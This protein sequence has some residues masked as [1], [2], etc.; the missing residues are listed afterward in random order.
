MYKYKLSIIIPTYNGAGW[1]EDTMESVLCQLDEYKDEVEFI[2]R[3]N[4]SSDNTD[5]IVEKLNNKYHGLIKYDRRDTT[6]LADI[7]YRESVNMSNGVFVLMIGDDDLLFPNFI[8]Y[9]LKL[10]DE[11][12][13]VSLFY[14]NRISTSRD[15]K[16][17]MLK[18]LNPNP[19]FF[20]KYDSPEEFIKDYSLGPDFM[21]VNVF[22][23]ECFDKGLPF[24]K[25]KYYG[26]EWYSIILAGLRGEKCMSLF[27]P[28]I[29]QRVPRQR[30][31]DDQALLF[32]VIG[33]HNMFSDITE[34]Y[35]SALQ[36]WQKNSKDDVDRIRFIF[37]GAILNKNLY[38]KKWDEL[39]EKLNTGEQFLAYA[40][41][42]FRFLI[43]ILKVLILYPYR[44]QRFFM[45][46]VKSRRR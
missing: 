35:P 31:W 36:S 14:F 5:F 32:V 11:N 19:E 15:Y 28:M 16:G 39:R 18:H 23:R 30:T 24:A 25:E 46:V 45:R 42:H 22:K 33:V 37:N 27:S 40:L 3:N 43:P 41:L 13:E 7:N 44:V 38:L 17:A 26:V 20:K 29:L 10:I 4:G 9:I 12:P 8:F 21:S 1:I 2:V 6:I 34:F